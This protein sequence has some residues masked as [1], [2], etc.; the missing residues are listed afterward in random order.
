MLS[1]EVEAAFRRRAL[2][3]NFVE[4]LS[5]ARRTNRELLLNR[6]DMFCQFRD[7]LASWRSNTVFYAPWLK[8]KLEDLT[9]ICPLKSDA[10]S[11]AFCPFRS[12]SGCYLT[13]PRFGCRQKEQVSVEKLLR[14]VTSFID[15]AEEA[16]EKS[17]LF[18]DG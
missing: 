1:A 16:L 3:T 15:K 10:D 12:H 17:P 6:V 13:A 5:K 9:Y 11:C 14:K 18:S 2:S 7:L 8:H 4:K